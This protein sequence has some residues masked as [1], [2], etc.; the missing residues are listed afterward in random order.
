MS[1]GKCIRDITCHRLCLWLGQRGPGG[2][3]GRSCSWVVREEAGATQQ[4][5]KAT[6]RASSQALQGSACPWVA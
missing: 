3:G 2:W 1:C 5:F 6:G 4:W